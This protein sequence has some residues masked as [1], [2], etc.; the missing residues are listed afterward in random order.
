MARGTGQ[1]VATTL[2]PVVSG[3]RDALYLVLNDIIVGA[4]VGLFPGYGST[5][6]ELYDTAPGDTVNSRNRVY[7]SLGDRTVGP[8][9][10]GDAQ[11]F[12]QLGLGT[13]NSLP[14]AFAG[15]QWAIAYQD[16]SKQVGNGTTD[17][18][19]APVANHQTITLANGNFNSA[20]V[21][22]LIWITGATNPTNNGVFTVNSFISPTQ[23]TIT[24]SAG[25]LENSFAGTVHT[26]I[27]DSENNAGPPSWAPTIDDG[28]QIDIFAERNQY[29]VTVVWIQSGNVYLLAMGSALRT[30]IA[31]LHQG[32]ARL[33]GGPYAPGATVLNVDRDL[34]ASLQVTTP[35]QRVWIYDATRNPGD[36]LPTDN[37]EIVFV[38]NVSATQVTLQAP[39]LVN[40]HNA[41]AILGDDPSP[42]YHMISTGSS[43]PTVRMCSRAD[44]T[45]VEATSSGSIVP[46][47]SGIIIASNNPATG[48]GFFVGSTC[49]I[50]MSNGP[51]SFRGNPQ[52]WNFWPVGAQV[53]RDRMIPNFTTANAQKLFKSLLNTSFALAIGPGAT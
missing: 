2:T 45:Y 5:T 36:P 17:S 6:F 32:V 29:E 39:G 23:I 46:Q 8:G 1:Y 47:T 27:R 34:T 41:N 14:S 12:Y 31:P 4:P 52:H 25:V 9:S 33:T 3:Q 21:S 11:V 51:T 49:G 53:D 48:T 22:R 24:N 28:A 16:W 50:V 7:R 20:L 38:S 18:I 35:A 30:H 43:S 10:T 44:G 19:T 15:L 13:I 42:I 26:F 40:T 37:T